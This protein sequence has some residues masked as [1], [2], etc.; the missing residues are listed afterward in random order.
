MF[1]V[2]WSSSPRRQS[3]TPSPAARA[4]RAALH[5]LCVREVRRVRDVRGVR[6]GEERLLRHGVPLH[7]GR[8]RGRER[9]HVVPLERRRPRAER[10]VEAVEL[11]ADDEARGVRDR[12]QVGDHALH[13]GGVRDR[14][15]RARR[16]VQIPGHHE[17]V[18]ADGGERGEVVEAVAPGQRHARHGAD[19]HR[20]PRAL[21]VQRL[22]EL[23]R[24]GHEVRPVG[25]R[26]GLEVDVDAVV[27]VGRDERRD[28]RH[29]RVPVGRAREQRVQRRRVLGL[30]A[31]LDGDAAQARPAGHER[32]VLP[33]ERE[34]AIDVV[35]GR[36]DDG[37]LPVVA[38]QILEALARR[39]QHVGIGRPGRGQ[40]R[41]RDGVECALR[42]AMA[43]AVD[44]GD[45]EVV[46]RGRRE[47]A[48]EESRAL[49][50][51][52]QDAVAVDGVAPHG[53]VGVVRGIP[54]QRHAGV[55]DG[56]RA[57]VGGG[58]G[59]QLIAARV[60]LR[61]GD[62]RCRGGVA[63]PVERAHGE[64]VGGGAGDAGGRQRRG[65]TARQHLAGAREQLVA[66]HGVV[67]ARGAEHDRERILRDGRDLQGRRPRR[68]VGVALR[69]HEDL[70]DVRPARVDAAGGAHLP[71]P[72]A[73]QQRDLAP[74]GA[75][76]HR[77]HGLR[78][79]AIAGD[80]QVVAPGPRGRGPAERDAR[81]RDDGARLRG[82][83]RGARRT[84]CGARGQCRHGER[85]QAD[86]KRRR[87]AAP[88]S[89]GGTCHLPG[90]R[91]G[92][93]DRVPPR[94]GRSSTQGCTRHARLLVR[95]SSVPRFS[96]RCAGR[97]PRTAR[98][99][100]ARGTRSRGRRRARP[101]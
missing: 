101:R 60:R 43:A 38:L 62:G 59:R 88:A 12:Q 15:G 34:V 67:V 56:Q 27:A 49:R 83:L 30:D 6:V 100:R 45:G 52:E 46:R 91:H 33:R 86:G 54:G 58:L 96:R 29:E 72:A 44:R 99:P 37:D 11:R 32:V 28:A 78:E 97:A 26:A 66:L 4:G 69:P 24:E 89:S 51:T 55:G 22:R 16:P 14:A 3:P 82:R 18:V 40:R 21:R 31:R 47:A 87:G 71:E 81:C 5:A 41:L 42:R 92:Y 53:A 85:E 36:R 2:S 68:R 80:A 95:W 17:E 70:P 13:P 35:V 64:G 65:R 90:Y 1:H 61:V 84:P 50:L 93:T 10:P 25:G 77:L 39:R 9:R 73:R 75:H 7:R 74:D 48:R 94:G 57:H 98:G 8:E 76:V 19:G 23:A 20:Q 63:G 79:A